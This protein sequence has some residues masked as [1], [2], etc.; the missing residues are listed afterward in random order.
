MTLLRCKTYFSIDRWV[1]CGSVT[2]FVCVSMEFHK[3]G[4][5]VIVEGVTYLSGL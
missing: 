2:G 1:R 4:L 3:V 5:E